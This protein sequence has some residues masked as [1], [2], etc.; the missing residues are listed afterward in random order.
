MSTPFDISF[1]TGIAVNEKG[2]PAGAPLAVSSIRLS[3]LYALETGN[4]RLGV[5]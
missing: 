4:L 1:F 3:K 2:A 5:Y